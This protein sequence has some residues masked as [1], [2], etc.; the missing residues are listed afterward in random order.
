MH[1]SILVV[2][3]TRHELSAISKATV[4]ALLLEW[5]AEAWG[6]LTVFVGDAKGV[7]A[8]VREWCP[9]YDAVFDL[10]K[11]DWDEH[12]KAAGPIR[13]TQMVQAAWDSQ[14]AGATVTFLAFP[15]MLKPST[16]TTDCVTKL[17]R[18]KIPGR[19]VLVK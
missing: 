11:A 15:H 10:F 5:H 19:V 4:R 13:N 6:Q 2:T 12:G 1:T 18:A 7:D 17:V 9:D 8:A 3:G 14:D 16:G